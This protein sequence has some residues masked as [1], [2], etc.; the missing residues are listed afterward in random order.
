MV[1]KQGQY[2]LYSVRTVMILIIK[3]LYFCKSRIN[4]ENCVKGAYLGVLTN[5]SL[6]KDS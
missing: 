5:C 3:I 4:D 1:L 2:G 6:K